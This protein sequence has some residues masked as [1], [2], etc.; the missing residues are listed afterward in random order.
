MMELDVK[1]WVKR[2]AEI[3]DEEVRLD[4]FNL[5][6]YATR[7]EKEVAKKFDHREDIR[8][9]SPMCDLHFLKDGKWYARK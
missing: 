7:L 2:V 5:I 4:F 1:T 6:N 8:I 3:E 9:P